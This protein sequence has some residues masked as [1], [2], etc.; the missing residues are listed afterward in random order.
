M[1]EYSIVKRSVSLLIDARDNYGNFSTNLNIVMSQ[2]VL[3]VV[4]GMSKVLKKN[5]LLKAV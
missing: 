5:I 3:E 1:V 2:L 4:S